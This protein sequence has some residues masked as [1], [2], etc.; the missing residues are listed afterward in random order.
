MF[1]S[2]HPTIS[3]Q[4]LSIRILDV[5]VSISLHLCLKFNPRSVLSIKDNLF[6]VYLF[7]NLF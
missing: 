4:Y 7:F 2:F 1:Y 6:K 5:M 3:K